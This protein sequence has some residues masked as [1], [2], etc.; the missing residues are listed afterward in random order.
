MQPPVLQW[1]YAIGGQRFGP[2]TLEGMLQ[3]LQQGHW[4]LDYALVW[5]EGMPNWQAPRQTPELMQAIQQSTSASDP[6]QHQTAAAHPPPNMSPAY[7]STYG[8]AYGAAYGTMPTQGIQPQALP[9]LKRLGQAKPVEAVNPKTLL[10]CSVGAGLLWLFGIILAL[11]GEAENADIV[12]VFGGIL[13]FAGTVMLVAG[14][15][16]SKMILQ[17]MWQLIQ[18]YTNKA[19]PGQAIGYLFIPFYNFY[20]IFIAL[21][22][23]SNETNRILPHFIK[24]SQGLTALRPQAGTYIS[25]AIFW[26]ITNCLLTFAALAT[27]VGS[28]AAVVWLVLALLILP[29]LVILSTIAHTQGAKLINWAVE[30][31]GGKLESDESLQAA[32]TMQDNPSAAAAAGASPGTSVGT[33]SSRDTNTSS[34]TIVEP[35]HHASGYQ[36]PGES[37]AKA[38]MAIDPADPKS[39]PYAPR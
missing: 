21:G 31:H 32:I 28:K 39:S 5:R 25:Y 6:Y 8:T 7:G 36:V 22:S 10:V 15:I 3:A 27:S 12:A 24:E 19:T 16:Y 26:L 14:S 17:R 37:E 4:Q 33:T 1:Y 18:P 9:P 11:I 34:P 2:L 38:D 30:H 23:W 35:Q 13:C 20:W 29:V